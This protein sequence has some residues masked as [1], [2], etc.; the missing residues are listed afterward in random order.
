MLPLLKFAKKHPKLSSFIANLTCLI[1]LRGKNKVNLSAK[2]VVF[3]KTKIVASG[4]DNSLIIGEYSMI[5]GCKFVFRGSSNRVMISDT[6]SLGGG[7][8]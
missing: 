8:L 1:S 4:N 5:K 2:K 3:R 6:V 7:S